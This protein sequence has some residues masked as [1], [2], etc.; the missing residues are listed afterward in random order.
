MTRFLNQTQ[1]LP[2]DEINRYAVGII[3]TGAIGS[4]VAMALT[5]MGFNNIVT[6]DPDKIEDHNIANQMF[7]VADIGKRKANATKD[8]VK[9]FSGENI[10][11]LATKITGRK[12]SDYLNQAYPGKHQILILA[13]DSLDVRKDI[14]DGLYGYVTDCT[15]IDARM[16]AKT[17]RVMGFKADDRNETDAYLKTLV[18]D[19]EAVQEHC[20]QKSIIYT[21]LGVAAEVCGFVHYIV[22]RFSLMD[23]HAPWIPSPVIFDYGTGMRLQHRHVGDVVKV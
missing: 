2:Q 10:I 7:P 22:M 9:M 6:W 11:S 23:R 8:M 17:Y 15:V 20:G 21:V 13:V 3:G 4:F 12:A 14:V 1:L 16:G 19:G 18:P 5:K